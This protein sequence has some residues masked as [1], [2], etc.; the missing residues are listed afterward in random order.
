M[1]SMR[2]ERKLEKACV[3]E[4]GRAQTDV[5]T[6]TELN[7]VEADGTFRASLGFLQDA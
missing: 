7:S 6:L 5:F 1:T 3:T 4:G 2:Q